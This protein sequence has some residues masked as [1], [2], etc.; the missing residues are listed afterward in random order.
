MKEMTDELVSDKI[1][2]DTNSLHEMRISEFGMSVN[3]V[4]QPDE[5]FKKY[6]AIFKKYNVYFTGSFSYSRDGIIKGQ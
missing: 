3:G 6:S 4:K 1:I 5:V 2:P